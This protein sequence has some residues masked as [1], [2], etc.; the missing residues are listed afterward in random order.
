MRKL[1]FLIFVLFALFIFSGEI[2]DVYVDYLWFQEVGYLSSFLT[3]LTSKVA[4]GVVAALVLFFVLYLNLR[5]AFSVSWPYLLGAGVTAL[6][7][8]LVVSNSWETVL[9]YFNAQPFGVQDPVFSR[10]ISFYVFSL[11]FYDFLWNAGF[12][13]FLFSTLFAIA[14]YLLQGG[15]FTAPGGWETP[16][17]SLQLSPRTKRH[18]SI[19]AA[20]FAFLLAVK[21]Y[22]DRFDL[23]FTPKSS[24][25]GAGYAELKIQLPILT[26]L[27]IA[28]LLVSLLFLLTPRFVGW[29]TPLIGVGLVILLAFTGNIA[30][31]II[32]QYVVSPDELNLEKPYIEN[33]IKYTRLA[34]D[35][36]SVREVDFPAEQNLTL[37][38]LERNSMTV[39]NIRLWDWRPMLRTY[40]QIQLIRTYYN[41][42]DMDID[43]Y[44]INS[45]YRQVVLSA[46]EMDTNL[47][48]SRTWVNEHLFYTHGYGLAMSP[49]SKVSPEGLPV[50]Y[51]KDIPPKSRYFNITRPEIYY[52]ELANSYIIVKTTTRE[53]DYPRGNKNVYTTYQGS[54]GIPLSNV[55]RKTAM[56]V[57]FNTIKILVSTSLKPESRIIFRRNIKERTRYITPYLEFD[58]DPYLVTANGKLYWI[59]DAYTTTNRYPYS[60]PTKTRRGS[61]NYIRNS[62]KIVVDAYNGTTRYYIAD[63]NDP[64]LKTYQQIFP[65]VFKPL[66][67]MPPEL[68]QHIRYPENLFRIQTQKY[69][70]YHMRDPRVFYNKED[71]WNIP[72]ELYESNQIEMEPYYL[73]TKLL[74]GEKEEFLLLLPFTPR[75]KDNMIAWM[76]VRSD[77][78]HYGEKIVYLFPKD[79]LIYGPIQIEARIDQN[80]EISQLFTLWGQEGTSIIRGNLLVIPIEKSLIYVEPIYLRAEQ[81]SAIPELKRVIVAFGD[82]ITMQKT[83]EES[84]NAI[85]KNE[86]TTKEIEEI[87]PTKTEPQTLDILKQAATHYKQAKEYLKQGNWTGFGQELEKLGEI[88]ETKEKKTEH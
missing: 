40:K 50:F 87:T 39:D 7:F 75:D 59:L 66:T 73:I 48:P 62:V 28:A 42:N 65:K 44:Q 9:L 79:K 47:L 35:L 38:D 1:G 43:R 20:V 88:L 34:Y 74:Q 36:E 30:T 3:I 69:T 71:I 86:T 14:V 29:K 23:L 46:R 8:G 57:K 10:D 5:F 27:V 19:L 21:Y 41:F 85:F 31:G 16:G 78:P 64:L 72:K 37:Q 81:R 45:S 25:F 4:L 52:G 61:L 15:Y 51:I 80:S 2:I 76:A 18:F 54:G 17:G 77:P 22:L 12:S 32:Q 70:T 63:P 53:F 49:V 83:L 58:S 24:F 56:T 13:M 11:P 67:K 82:Q 33:S 68:L 6:F 55:I 60:E 84:I 26:L